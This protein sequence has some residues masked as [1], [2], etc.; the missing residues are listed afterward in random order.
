VKEKKGVE[1]AINSQEKKR[2]FFS[3]DLGDDRAAFPSNLGVQAILR[4]SNY[5][6]EI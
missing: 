1:S 6:G 4:Y 3:I 2:L 5:Y